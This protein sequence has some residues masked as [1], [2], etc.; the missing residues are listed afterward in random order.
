VTMSI[1]RFCFF[2]IYI[3]FYVVIVKI[4]GEAFEGSPIELTE[5][6]LCVGQYK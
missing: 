3:L 5:T 6:R 4:E 2:G 1:D